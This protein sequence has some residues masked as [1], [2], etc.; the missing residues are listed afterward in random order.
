M[1]RAT[2]VELG[3]NAVGTIGPKARIASGELTQTEVDEFAS[4]LGTDRFYDAVGELG[5]N[6]AGGTFTLVVADALTTR[7]FMAGGD[8]AAQHAKTMYKWL[9]ENA[10]TPENR[11]VIPRQCIDG[12]PLAPG[13]AP[14]RALIGDHDSDHG[15]DDCGAEKRLPDILAFISNN[16]DVLR[17]IAVGEGVEVDE[18]THAMI[19][20]GAQSLIDEG[21]VSDALALRNSFTEVAGE[22][23]ISCLSGGHAEVAARKNRDPGITLN[24]ARVQAEYGTKIEAFNV[25]AGVFPA[26][27]NVVSITPEE[28]HQKTVAMEYYNTATALVLADASLRYVR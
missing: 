25:D 16:G 15:K 4:E 27:A 28:A 12:R 5:P 13:S 9:I 3:G 23:C 24:R 8:N 20:S 10:D 19:V 17:E 7:R 18:R 26:A 6:A 21:Y 1:Q 14:S 11:L 22:E 2:V